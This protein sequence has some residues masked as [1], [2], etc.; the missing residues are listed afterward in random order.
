[1]LKVGLDEEFKPTMLANLFDIYIYL[2]I[3][4]F[5]CV[6]VHY[7]HMYLN[8]NYANFLFRNNML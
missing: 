7:T 8:D 2:H 1:M 6:G 5:N 3:Y 4:Y